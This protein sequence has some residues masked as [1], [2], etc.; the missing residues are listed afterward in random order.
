MS[1]SLAFDWSERSPKPWKL[2]GRGAFRHTIGKN[3][4]NLGKNLLRLDPETQYYK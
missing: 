3:K 2:Q 1:F 4:Q